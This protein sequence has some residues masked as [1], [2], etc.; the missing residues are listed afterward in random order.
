[1]RH[2]VIITGD[3]GIPRD[4]DLPI[5]LEYDA[6]SNTDAPACI[7][8]YDAGDVKA[9]IHDER[10]AGHTDSGR[11]GEEQEKQE[12]QMD[13]RE[14]FERLRFWRDSKN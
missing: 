2:G 12:K 9:G 7:G 8:T 10:R 1:M 11:K 5:V 3:A 6:I 14:E 13:R 4:D